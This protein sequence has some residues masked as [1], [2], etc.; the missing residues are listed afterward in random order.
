MSKPMRCS[1]YDPGDGLKLDSTE[2]SRL[3]GV[4]AGEWDMRAAT[5]QSNVFLG[6]RQMQKIGR[7]KQRMMRNFQVSPGL[8]IAAECK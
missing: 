4:V 6:S 5:E 1:R 3:D 2:V 7:A 8:S